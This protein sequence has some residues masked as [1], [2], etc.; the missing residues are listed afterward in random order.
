M[1]VGEALRDLGQFLDECETEGAVESVG[2]TGRGQGDRTGPLTA[3]IKLE[4]STDADDGAALALGE[5]A[6]DG[7]GGLRLGFESAV[8]VVPR[9]DHDI[10]IEV[11]EAA[12]REGTVEV[13]LSASVRVED[14]GGA[15]P[16]PE[17][18][19]GTEPEVSAT[20]TGGVPPFRDPE[21]LERVYD[22][23]DTFAEMTDEIGMDVT[24]ETVRRYMIDHGIHEPNSYDTGPESDAD[25]TGGAGRPADAGEPADEEPGAGADT[26]V[27][28]A[29]GIGLPD[30]V[31]VETLVETVKR[32]NT[33][34]EV[35]RNI[36]IEREDALEML[37]ELNL[38]DL[39]VGRLATED[40]RDI[41]REEVVQRLRE[42][43]ATA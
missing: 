7:E 27:V 22:S 35:K 30:D 42:A 25:T 11:R 14:A 13:T 18:S 21:L 40:E 36:G 31:T 24:A 20:A 26:P 4:L 39:V 32:S 16:V 3:E 33:I 29:D 10:D 9:A 34:Y 17:V 28:L 43:S 15:G 37:R 1:S 23:C 41:S 5:T 38:L 19:T 2:L 12:L 8:P 6:V